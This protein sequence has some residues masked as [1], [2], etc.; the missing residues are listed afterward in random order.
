M[1]LTHL[2]SATEL[3]EANGIR[4]LTDPWL[5]DGAYYGSWFHYPPYTGSIQELAYDY[6]Y[7]SHIHPDHMDKK[8]MAALDKSAPVLIH[9]YAE[10]FLKRNLEFMG[11]R[12]IELPNN[13]T[14]ELGN[15]VTI[16]ILAADNCNPQL[17]SKFMGCGKME[18]KF[19]STQVDSLSVISD[20]MYTILNTNDCPYDLSHEA[21]DAILEKYKHIDFLLVGYAG[22]G[23]YPQCFYFDSEED[24]KQAI[25][26]KK[27][28]FLDYG[29]AFLN[30]IRPRFY[31]PFAG[32]YT[33]GGSLAH[34][35]S[36]RGVPEIFE[37]G[38]LYAKAMK[39]RGINSQLV[40]LNSESTF[41]I[42]NETPSDPYTP[43][44]VAEKQHYIDTVISKIPL[45]YE[46]S[47]Y[48]SQDDIRELIPGAVKRFEFK[49]Q[50]IDF[51]TDTQLIIDI[52]GGDCLCIHPGEEYNYLPISDA[53]ETAPYVYIRTDTRLLLSLLK[54][55]RYAHW[56]NAEIGSHLYFRRNPN[57][58]ERG[59]Y[60]CLCFLHN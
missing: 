21:I 25:A 43:Y 36:D 17:C 46:R 47:E 59:L 19:G 5:E 41:D 4:I 2:K 57:S 48:P 53:L 44:S 37:A 38:E 3:I 32:T 60:H 13:V 31:M 58:F 9:S 14:Y 50:E 28:Q 20:G 51:Q 27:E 40:L 42:S 54:G 52:G 15:G 34:L 29:I 35:N 22:A 45:D 10:K 33:L 7:V 39:D 1:K 8:T 6:I 16:D 18:S 55:P 26:T 24:K 49:R 30:K 56:N 12:V 23:P 11:F